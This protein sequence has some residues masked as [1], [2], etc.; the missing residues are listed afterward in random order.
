MATRL[1]ARRPSV[2]PLVGAAIAG[3]TVGGVAALRGPDTTSPL[4]GVVNLP[5]SAF[6]AVILAAAA[7]PLVLRHWSVGIVAFMAWLPFEDL[8]RKYAGNDLRVYVVKDLLFGLMLMGLARHL[9]AARAWRRATGRARPALILLIMWAV[10][11]AV[12]AALDDPRVPL[13]GLRLDFLYVP[14]V[15]VGYFL[16]SDGRRFRRAMEW[17]TLLGATVGLFGL[18]QAVIGPGFLTPGGAAPGLEHLLLLRARG[19]VY[20]PTG[21]FVEPGRFISMA[22]IALVL[23]LVAHAVAERPLR[24]LCAGGVIVAGI[25][26]YVSGGKAAQLAAIGLLLIAAGRGRRGRAVLRVAAVATVAVTMIVG[27]SLAFPTVVGPRLTYYNQALNPASGD[28][29]W[30]FRWSRYSESTLLGLHSGG[31][32]GR[33]TGTQSLGLQYVY[34]GEKRSSRGLYHL[35]SGYGTIAYELGG[36]GLALW[37]SWA[38]LW[39]RRLWQSARQVRGTEYESAAM[40]ATGWIVFLLFIAFFAGS[41]FFQNYVSNAFLW[42]LSGVVFGLADLV[43]TNAREQPALVLTAPV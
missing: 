30:A 11:M 12:P 28:N 15:A 31:W 41:Q 40:V 38:V 26:V 43:R 29:E 2:L 33:G 5:I 16:A 14:L 6:I 7:I 21:T 19:R 17:L 18:L 20:Q 27:A 9:S 3:A 13:I 34:G 8:V 42:L 24:R 22:V 4:S 10:A 36:V 32:I 25:V 37:L 1:T 35:E 39:T 23:A